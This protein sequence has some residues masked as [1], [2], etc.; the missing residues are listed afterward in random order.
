MLKMAIFHY[1]MGSTATLKLNS[2]YSILYIRH[3][4]T[5]IINKISISFWQ[6]YIKY[7]KC[8]R[9]AYFVF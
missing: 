3:C 7:K 9:C 1:K 2:I 4:Q 8:K 6:F 5:F